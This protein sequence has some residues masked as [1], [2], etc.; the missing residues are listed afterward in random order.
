MFVTI[1]GTPYFGYLTWGDWLT[2]TWLDM[3]LMTWGDVVGP[4]Q[5]Q[6]L[7]GSNPMVRDIVEDR[8]TADFSILDISHAYDFGKGQYVEIMDTNLDKIFT[9]FIDTVSQRRVTPGGVIEHKISCV[10]NHYLTD[11]R[12]LAKAFV[13]PDTIADAV[14]WIITNILA[15]EGIAA[16]TI[17]APTAIEAI[18]Y[19]YVTVA[20][21]LDDLAA[22]AGCTWFI[23]VNKLLYFIPRSTYAAAWDITEAGDVLSNVLA[24][25]FEV[26]ETNP[27]YRN[28]QFIRGGS[29]KTDLQ[30]EIKVGDGESSSWAVGFKIAEEPDVS[31]STDGGKTYTAK[32]M[33]IKGV[34]SGKDWYWSANDQVILQDAMAARLAVGDLLKIEYYGLYQVILSSADFIEILD[35]QAVEYT[36][37]GINDAVRD[38]PLVTTQDAGLNEANALLDHYAEIGTKVTY[39]TIVPGL[40]AGT[41]Q[42]ITSAIHNLDDDF[43]ITQVEKCPMYFED[44]DLGNALIMYNIQAVSGPVEDY[45]TKVFL[46]LNQGNAGASVSGTTSVVLA[47]KTFSEIASGDIWDYIVADG[48]SDSDSSEFP[49]YEVGDE[50]K[51]IAMYDSDGTTELFRKYRVAQTGS[52]DS[53]K[54]VTTF[55]INSGECNTHWHYLKLFGGDVASDTAYTGDLVATTSHVYTKNSLEALQIVFTVT[56]S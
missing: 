36:T 37:S 14:N 48:A 49:S 31:V 33:G 46:K 2:T 10:D 43:L 12:L 11:K 56:E 24:E 1:S 3:I 23:D 7:A 44:Q 45:W 5:S 28:Q 29:S 55:I 52:A 38:D 47:L 25:S 27:E 20:T 51:Y 19:D 26:Y 8:S 15:D 42:H 41:L 39:S 6:V 50:V 9:G 21:A 32:T 17:T 16:G 4:R 22:Y 53:G 13:S 34:D 54:F 30:T 35:R 18:S 40:E